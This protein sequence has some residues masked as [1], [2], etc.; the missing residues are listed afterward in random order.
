VH[1]GRSSLR[2][3]GL[4]V[5]DFAF[6]PEP[7]GAG[8]HRVELRVLDFNL[9]GIGCYRRC[10]VIE[11]GG[12]RDAAFVDGAWLDYMVMAILETDRRA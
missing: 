7:E 8:L 12:E 1:N 4:G 9:R 3:P 5:L 6:T 11:E 2:S 10:S